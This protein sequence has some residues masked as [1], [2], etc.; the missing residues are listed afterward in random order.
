MFVFVYAT[1]HYHSSCWAVVN[2][3]FFFLAFSNNDGAVDSLV[4]GIWGC[5]GQWVGGVGGRR[6]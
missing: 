3:L 6:R 5:D 1:F 2:E 4:C